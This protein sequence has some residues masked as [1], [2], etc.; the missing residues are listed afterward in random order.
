MKRF[1]GDMFGRKFHLHMAACCCKV[2]DLSSTC[3][4]NVLN[5]MFRFTVML[6]DSHWNI[7]Q[8][9][10]L[11]FEKYDDFTTFC[12]L[13]FEAIFC[14]ICR[15]LPA[16]LDTRWK[17]SILSLCSAV[18]KITIYLITLR[19]LMYNDQKRITILKY[20]KY[21]PVHELNL[22]I[23]VVRNLITKVNNVSAFL[24]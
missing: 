12:L 18:V 21:V 15:T 3:T 16:Q 11:L 19:F 13:G 1:V 24:H 9:R 10:Y 14:R 5:V 20:T 4:W 17:L 23:K 8:E 7:F 6:F 2:S 22:T